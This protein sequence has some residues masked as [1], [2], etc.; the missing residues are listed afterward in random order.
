MNLTISFYMGLDGGYHQNT[1]LL[2]LQQIE[3]C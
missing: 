1:Q 2:K 3:I